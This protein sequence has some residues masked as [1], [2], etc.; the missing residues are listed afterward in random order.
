MVSEVKIDS[1]VAEFEVLVLD[2]VRATVVGSGSANLAEE[3]W[4]VWFK[5]KPK[6]FALNAAVPVHMTGPFKEP[7]I[8]AQKIGILRKVAGA[9]GLFVFPPAAV[10]GL[11]EFGAGNPCVE[12]IDSE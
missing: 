7:D 4:D 5:P 1:G 6:R 8:E 3:T 11:A 9:V 2:T 12:L 10:A